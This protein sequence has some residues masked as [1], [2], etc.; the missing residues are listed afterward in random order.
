MI[1]MMHEL[2][3]AK[4]HQ[5]RSQLPENEQF[6]SDL[7]VVTRVVPPDESTE[8]KASRVAAEERVKAVVLEKGERVYHGDLLTFQKFTDAKLMRANCVRALDRFEFMG[9]CRIQL[10]HMV[11][12][13]R[14]QDIFVALP[15][16]HNVDDPGT[17][18]HGNAVMGVNHWFP[19]AKK[20]IVRDGNYERCHQHLKAFQGAHTLNMWD[21]FV[22]EEGIEVGVLRTEED[23]LRT[24]D[25][26]MEHYG[27]RYWWDPD[28]VDPLADKDDLLKASRDQVVR[29]VLNLTSSQ[30]EHE[31]DALALLALRRTA[32]AF[33]R[34]KSSKSKYALHL[35]LDLV[36]E[37]GASDRT[38]ARMNNLATVNVSGVK[39]GY[40]FR[41]ERDLIIIVLGYNIYQKH[42]HYSQNL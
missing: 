1:E 32:V 15:D 16:P 3:L 8:A 36:M 4:L 40:L 38:R 37:L 33:F 30:A 23:V 17:M 25:T 14:A 42:I 28:F 29:L 10:F 22:K 26:M 13:M 12:A 24:L 35:L 20:K 9:L 18:S 5:I 41:S 31:N 19:K 39:G 27:A 7:E 34:S 2:Q 6:A 11:M 21:N